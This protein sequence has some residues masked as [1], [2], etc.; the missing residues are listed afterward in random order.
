MHQV[1]DPLA[2]P[3]S[4][5]AALRAA[6]LL[7][8]ATAAGTALPAALRPTAATAAP[9]GAAPRAIT[10]VRPPAVPLAVRSPY[11]TTWQQADTLPGTWST[12]WNGRI[13]ALC[14]IARID[15]KPWLFAGAPGTPAPTAMTQADLTVTATRSVYTLT[16][17]GVTLTVTFL[18]PVEPADIQ[19]QSVPFGYLTVRAASNDGASHRVSVYVDVSAEWTH[20]DDATPVAWAQR[21]TGA[22]QALS[23]TPASPGV[24]AEHNDQ[25]SWGSMVLA[26]PTGTGLTWQ[27]GEDTAVRGNAATTGTLPNT[28]DSGGPRAINDRWPVAGL[29]R[30]LGTVGGTPAEVTLALGHVRTPAVSYLGA[31]LDPWW[32]HYWSDWPAMLDWFL[33]DHPTALSRATA[34]DQKLAAD[35]KAAAG[36]G[37]TGDHYAAICALA[38]RQAVAGTELVNRGGTPWAMLKEISSD[39]NVSTV[40][41]IYPAFPAF[42]YLAPNYLQLLLEPVLEYAE[43]GGWPGE[44]AEHD[45]GSSYPN[46][47]GHNDGKEEDMPVEESANMLLM[48]AMTIQHLPADAAKAFATGHY[49]ILRRWAEYLVGTALDPGNQQ[50]TDDFTGPIAHS[51][52]L[53]LKGIVGLGA[54]S[55]VAATA[56]NTADHDRYLSTARSYISQWFD[57]AKDPSGSHLKLAYDRDGTWSLKYNGYPD[58]LLGLDLVPAAVADLESAWY[59][60]QAGRYGVLLDPRNNYTKADW[61]LWTAAWL[62]TRPVRDTLVNG[63]YGFANDTPQRTPFSDW[64]VV[65]SAARQGFSDRPV[66]G[67]ILSLLPSHAPSSAR[68]TKIQ[69][70]HSGKVLAVSGM[71]TDNS[72]D[73]T[74]WSDNGTADHL[75]TVVPNG[76]G[77]VRIT[78]RHSGKVLAVHIQSLDDGAHVQQYVDNGTPDHNWRLVDAG[79]GL[80]KIVN[81]HSGKLLAVNGMSTSDGAQITQWPDNGTDDHLWR[82]LT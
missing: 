8:A 63:V 27:I 50:Q 67:G 43:H 47:A 39:G 4:R 38:A 2:R 72:A 78:N 16:G 30:D 52:N 59:A 64:Y 62:S 22:A 23:F 31:P 35:A 34:L 70:K 60:G 12:F 46:A 21:A 1:P 26:T 81:A 7:A 9:S 28:S 25:A 61:E 18:S 74:Q 24:L 75:W 17:G 29:M 66:I 36:G 77:T 44:F 45:I 54:M 58:L 51:V 49:P 37:I 79:N 11:L 33:A 40:D 3:L 32:K 41:V 71:S 57:K 53:A 19:R 56:G 68:W 65:A 42:L 80:V 20:G 13:T 14:G 6:G 10:P 5:R 73:V 82:L 55:I 48:S 76:D 15:D 69:N